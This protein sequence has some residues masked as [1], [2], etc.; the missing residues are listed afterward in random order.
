MLRSWL[1]ESRL[2]ALTPLVRAFA[3]TAK[4]TTTAAAAPATRPSRRRYLGIGF[5]FLRSGGG[6]S[7]LGLEQPL[8]RNLGSLGEGAD[9]VA[10]ALE[11]T[12]HNLVGTDEERAEV[13]NIR[14]LGAE[15]AYA[16]VEVADVLLVDVRPEA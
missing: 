6:G 15:P 7:D 5:P 16:L 3:G 2:Q 12:D 11:L 14:R 13:A 1:A 9:G 10:C 4:I 8:E